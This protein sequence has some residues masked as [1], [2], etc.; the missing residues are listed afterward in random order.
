MA[1]KGGTRFTASMAEVFPNGCH[2]VPGSIGEAMDYDEATKRR[3]PATDKVT[4]KPVY[5]CRVMDMDPAL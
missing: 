3:F 2:L 4:G 5:Q 1:L